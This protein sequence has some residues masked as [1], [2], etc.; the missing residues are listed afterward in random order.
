MCYEQKSKSNLKN[1][2]RFRLNTNKLKPR[3]V[4]WWLSGSGKIRALENGRWSAGTRF[5]EV[6]NGACDAALL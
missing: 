5:M 3:I 1:D 4:R 2:R 6:I